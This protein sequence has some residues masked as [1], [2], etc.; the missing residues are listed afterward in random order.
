MKKNSIET[1]MRRQRRIIGCQDI[2]TSNGLTTL[3]DYFLHTFAI[4]TKLLSMFATIRCVDPLNNLILGSQWHPIKAVIYIAFNLGAEILH[5]PYVQLREQYTKDHSIWMGS[6][7]S[8]QD[9]NSRNYHVLLTYLSGESQFVSLSLFYYIHL[10]T[11]SLASNTRHS[12]NES[13]TPQV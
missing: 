8:S 1:R 7:T 2:R 10:L 6:S 11:T 3:I 12:Y 9:Y 4:H 13:D 5:C